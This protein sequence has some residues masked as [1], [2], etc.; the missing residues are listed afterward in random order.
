MMGGMVNDEKFK[1]LGGATIRV[2]NINVHE[3]AESSL[4]FFHNY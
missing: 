4:R 2:N 3:F 1:A